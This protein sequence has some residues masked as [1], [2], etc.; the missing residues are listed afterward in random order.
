MKTPKRSACEEPRL[1]FGRW[2]MLGTATPCT[3][4]TQRSQYAATSGVWANG[5]CTV[6]DQ[7]RRRACVLEAMCVQAC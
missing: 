5:A 4:A 6:G 3:R 2:L 1:C 7:R